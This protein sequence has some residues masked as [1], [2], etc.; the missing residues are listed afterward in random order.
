MRRNRIIDQPSLLMDWN[1]KRFRRN[2]WPSFKRLFE[3]WRN[4]NLMALPALLHSSGIKFYAS[5][6]NRSYLVMNTNKVL[7]SFF[8]RS[9]TTHPIVL[10]SVFPLCFIFPISAESVVHI[11]WCITPT[12]IW[13]IEICRTDAC[14]VRINN[15]TPW[16]GTRV[17][18]DKL[19]G[20]NFSFEH[21]NPRVSRNV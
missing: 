5:R 10:Q 13:Y 1:F 4:L 9:P 2:D 11:S 19:R 16:H 20:W 6:G 18:R 14:F 15:N 3:S 21:D 7:R 17:Y 12:L 8:T